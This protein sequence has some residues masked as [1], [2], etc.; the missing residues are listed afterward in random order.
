[1]DI[2]A[3]DV[4]AFA[5]A[6]W[7]E[8]AAILADV[9]PERVRLEWG[10]DPGFKRHFER[11]QTAGFTVLPN[12]F[13]SPVPD[14]T[15]IGEA[16]TAPLSLP[17]VNFRVPAQLALLSELTRFRSEYDAFRE[18]GHD[19]VGKFRFGGAIPPIDA[20]LTYAMLRHLKPKRLIEVGAGLSTLLMAE[21][22]VANR[23]DGIA[24]HFASIDP[25]PTAVLN[26][27]FEGL[28]E[29]I[30][31]PVEKAPAEL[32]ASLEDGD[33][34]FIDSSHVLKPGNDVEFEYLQL[35]PSLRPGV[36]V[37]VHDIFLPRPYHPAWL[38]EERIFWNEQ[39][40]LAAFLSCN[41]DFEVLLA[42]NLLRWEHTDAM[43]SAVNAD[44]SSPN[45]SPGSFWMRRVS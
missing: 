36:I 43:A 25:Y 8:F 9:M 22:L 38:T 35:L 29:Q 28:S 16:L 40:L 39:Y 15:A 24:A 45:I 4:R 31:L 7:D 37:H 21:A 3:D 19:A 1:M 32:F 33:V 2:S 41:S 20:E 17:G 42:N 14:M 44:Y 11:W 12:H 26:E 23:A 30:Q 10:S 13:Y 6:N 27:P 5:R 18:R 34:L